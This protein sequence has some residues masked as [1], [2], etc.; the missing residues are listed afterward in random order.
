M[1]QYETIFKC[2]LTTSMNSK[3]LFINALKGRPTP[4]TARTPLAVHYCAKHAEIS[5]HEYST[6]AQSMAEAIIKYY[7]DFRPDAIWVSADTWVTA[8]AMGAMIDFPG[9]HEP[10]GGVG[11]PVIKTMGDISAIPAADPHRRGRQ[12]MML[13]ALARVRET[14]GDKTFIIGCFDQSPFS[15]A[16]ALAGLDRVMMKLKTDRPFVAA[17]MD[18]CEEHARAY[19]RAMADAGADMLATGDSPAGLIGPELYREVALPA[20]RRVFSALRL[21]TSVFLSLHICGNATPILRDMATS[22]AHILEIDHAVDMADACRIVPND[23]AILGN[24]DPVEIFLRGDA[25]AMEKACVEFL[26]KIR[27]AGRRRF[28]LASGCTI[29]PETPAIN[30]QTFLNME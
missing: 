28:V 1:N 10:P 3:E 13:Q 23:I 26:D 5:I 17:L 24:I 9:E 15:L 2:N 30:I 29:P 14:L 27:A 18:R 16:C 21:N 6:R 19:G 11:G 7:E 20:E 25:G 8:E 12:P 22:G 4:R